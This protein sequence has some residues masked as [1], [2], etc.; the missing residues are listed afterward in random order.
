MRKRMILGWVLIAVFATVHAIWAV[1]AD[2]KDRKS[3]NGKV[4]GAAGGAQVTL[5]YGR[6]NVGGRKIWGALVPFGQVW[7]AGA[8]EATTIAFDKNVLVDGKPVPAGRY[9]LFLEPK[10]AS[11]WTVIFNKVAD[12]WGAFKY[13]AKSDA[14]RIEVLSGPHAATETLEYVIDGGRVEMHWADLAVG[15]SVKAAD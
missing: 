10:D 2:D 1:R 4:E 9:A 11:M 12:Q 13:D 15:F 14:L 8:D 6:P 3:K 5:D 7:R